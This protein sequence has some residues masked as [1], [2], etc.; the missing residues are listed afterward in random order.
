[1]ANADLR[2]MTIGEV[3]DRTF[4]LYK[5]EFWLFAGIMSLPFFVLFIFNVSIGWLTRA[6]VARI[7]ASHAPA[8][9]SPT[10]IAATIGGGLLVIILALIL[11]SIGQAATI[12]AVSDLYLGRRASIRGSF[13][14]VRGHIF[15]VMGVI[16]LTGLLV[17]VGFILLIIP[18][19]MFACRVGVAVPAAM[20]ED[21]GPS[22][23]ISRS[24]ELTKGFAMQ[25]FLIFVLTWVL[26]IIAGVIL[27][28]PFTLMAATPRPHVLPFGL[29]MLQYVTGFISQVLVAPVGAIAFSLMY[30][31][32]RVRKEAFDL[33]H[34]MGALG[35]GPS[36]SGTAAGTVLP[37]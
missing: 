23:A 32:L 2:P 3:L 34:L 12:F 21:K 35:P 16:F 18:G 37:A 10:M 27:Q 5:S 13:G 17:G 15:Q 14:Q 29:V 1:M 7:G 24:M 36:P 19:I 6:Q 9:I 22:T 11:S 33:E 31:N 28:L 20:L 30:Y 8:P 26:A 25:I 4:R